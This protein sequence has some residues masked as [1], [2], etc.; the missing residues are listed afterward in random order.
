MTQ[1]VRIITALVLSVRPL[2]PPGDRLPEQ[3]IDEVEESGIDWECGLPERPGVV[4]DT[5][6]LDANRAV[7]NIQGGGIPPSWCVNTDND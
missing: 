2:N 5:A 7:R 4:M 6:R 1:K 3:V